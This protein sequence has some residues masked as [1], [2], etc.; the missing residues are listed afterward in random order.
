MENKREEIAQRMIK[1]LE[2]A[3]SLGMK[4][5]RLEIAASLITILKENEFDYMAITKILQDSGL[6]E[7][8]SYADIFNSNTNS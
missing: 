6:T 2:E 1:Q 4:Y 8:K 3:F 7:D 5:K